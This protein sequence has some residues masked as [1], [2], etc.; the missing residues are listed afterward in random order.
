MATDHAAL[1]RLAARQ[2]GVFT[3][4]Q[5][6]ACGYAPTTVAR[7]VR[8]GSWRRV[9][10]G[11]YASA[12]ATLGFRALCWAALLLAGRGA[13]VSHFAAAQLW[14]LP[15]DARR[16]HV[17]LPLP[18]RRV[19]RPRVRWHRHHLADGDVQTVDGLP[20]TTLARTLLDCCLLL[21]DARAAALLDAALLRRRVQFDRLYAELRA[22]VGWRGTPRL[23][24]LVAT[25]DPAA[26]SRAEGGL[27]QG[28]RARGWTGWV[29]QHPVFDA[30]GL[31]RRIDVAFVGI[32]LA[33]EI[34]GWAWH[35]DPERFRADRAPWNRLERLGWH[36]MHV[37][38]ADALL[39]LDTVLDAIEQR[40]RELGATAA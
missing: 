14:H 31:I 20:V 7:R 18:R 11:V 17:T 2:H 10:A 19:P 27:H 39:R 5:A 32:R 24:R 22:R 38:A 28:L 13:A 1:A 4:A 30:A 37:P 16:V 23:L 26:Q 9:T 25:L 21:D 29:A 35:T 34:D 36:V 12:G 40:L 33:I 6:L 8:E 3:R 15:V